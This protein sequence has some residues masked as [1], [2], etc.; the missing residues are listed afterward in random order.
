[1]DIKRLENICKLNSEIESFKDCYEGTELCGGRDGPVSAAKL[2]SF[3]M[4][5]PHFQEIADKI[6]KLEA[7][8]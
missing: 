4:E 1:M 6:K 8:L 2:I 7:Q 3:L 5:N